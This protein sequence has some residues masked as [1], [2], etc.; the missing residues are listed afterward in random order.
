MNSNN[1]LKEGT[2]IYLQTEVHILK[3]SVEFEIPKTEGIV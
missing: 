2:C 3:W 1:D